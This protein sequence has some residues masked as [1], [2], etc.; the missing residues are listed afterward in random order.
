MFHLLPPRAS[1]Q[2]YLRRVSPRDGVR[3]EFVRAVAFDASNNAGAFHAAVAPP[4]P[5][6]RAAATNATAAAGGEQRCVPAQRPLCRARGDAPRP[7]ADSRR[8]AAAVDSGRT[9]DR[10]RDD[11][12]A[13]ARTFVV[14][15]PSVRARVTLSP[16]SHRLP[17]ASARRAFPVCFS[18]ASQFLTFA[19]GRRRAGGC[20]CVC[21]CVCVCVC[22]CVCEV[23]VPRALRCITLGYTTLCYMALHEVRV[24]RAFHCIT[25]RCIAIPFE[26]LHCMT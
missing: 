10:S 4:P 18:A 24:P 7:R 17:G 16:P 25:L 2:A 12:S 23:R 6:R 21:L 13:R 1:F 15:C 19:F 8:V 3:A 11:G 20:T 9:M 14:R 26:T 22:V 5:E